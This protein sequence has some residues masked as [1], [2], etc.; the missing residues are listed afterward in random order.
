M[1][2]LEEKLKDD[3]VDAMIQEQLRKSMGVGSDAERRVQARNPS[4][5]SGAL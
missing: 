5:L 3:M 4:L 1:Q 2:M